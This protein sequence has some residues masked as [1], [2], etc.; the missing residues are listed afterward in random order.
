MESFQLGHRKSLDGLRGVAILFVLLSHVQ[1]FPFQGGFIGVDLFFV[2]S[3]FLITSL[4]LEEWRETGDISLKAFYARRSLRLLPALVAMLTVVVVASAIFEPPAESAAM[5][6]AA[7]ITLL[8]SANWYMAAGAYPRDVLSPSWSLS[9]EEQFYVVWPLALFLMLRAGGSRRTM[10]TVVIVALVASAGLRAWVTRTPGHEA[11]AYFG[12]DTHADG[13]LAGALVAMA[14]SWGALPSKTTGLNV[15][16]AIALA[17]FGY[18]LW[19][20]WAFDPFFMQAGYV[21]FNLAA[22]ALIAALVASPWPAFRAIFEWEPLAW[23]GRISYG[24]YLWHMGVFWALPRCGLDLGDALWPS[25][26]LL[27]FAIAA[28]SFYG[29]ERPI[30]RFKKRFERVDRAAPISP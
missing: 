4:L 22:A 23:T 9:V 2:L 17:A 7:L 20:G 5:R 13:L 14:A 3:G 6:K 15:L 8:Y 30:L 1:K 27:T 11:R 21:V 26:F 29:L 28:A 10:A 25:A 16:G 19:K 12:A 18:F 24:L